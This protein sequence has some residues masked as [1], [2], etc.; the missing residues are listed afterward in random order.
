MASGSYRGSR[1]LRRSTRMFLLVLCTFY[2]LPLGA[3]PA[4]REVTD[5]KKS[6]QYN[7]DINICYIGGGLC[8]F[9]LRK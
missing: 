4:F 6:T 5:V 8:S 9:A 7:S 2:I 3:I 1:A